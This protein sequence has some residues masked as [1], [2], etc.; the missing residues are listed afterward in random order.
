MFRLSYHENS[1]YEALAV[2]DIT[3]GDWSLV[4]FPKYDH[5]EAKMFDQQLGVYS[6]YASSQDE[7]TVSV[8]N[9]P[10]N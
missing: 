9:H 2:S 8:E 5:G 4:T 3:Y 7:T 10:I 1:P 6:Q